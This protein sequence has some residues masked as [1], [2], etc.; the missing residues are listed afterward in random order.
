MPEIKLR[1]GENA[2]PDQSAPP[3]DAGHARIQTIAVCEIVAHN[4]STMA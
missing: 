2:R 3:Y 1:Y 4:A